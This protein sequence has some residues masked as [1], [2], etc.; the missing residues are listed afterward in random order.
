MVWYKQ[1]NAS[2]SQK[3]MKAKE[4][5]KP[6]KYKVVLFITA[7]IIIFIIPY[8]QAEPTPGTESLIGSGRYPLIFVFLMSLVVIIDLLSGNFVLRDFV[9]FLSF[10]LSFVVLY[11][12]VACLVYFLIEKRKK[13]KDE[14]LQAETEPEPGPTAEKSPYVL[15]LEE[16]DSE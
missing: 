2:L 8:L 6:S 7:F 12:I 4:I 1:L 14:P 16:P 10:L 3:L 9:F 13:N 5:L 11:L 15:H